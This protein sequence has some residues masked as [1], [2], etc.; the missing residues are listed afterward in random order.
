M[1]AVAIIGVVLWAARLKYLSDG[2]SRLAFLHAAM[3]NEAMMDS[4][5]FGGEVGHK[6]EAAQAHALELHHRGLMREYDRLATHPWESPPTDPLAGQAWSIAI[7]EP[8]APQYMAIP[9]PPA[10]Q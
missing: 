1:V 7:P 9:E 5:G 3:S 10:P 4:V 2:Y 6:G 8:P